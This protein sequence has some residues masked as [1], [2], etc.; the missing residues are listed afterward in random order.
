VA[1]EHLLATADAAIAKGEMIVA[2]LEHA[3]AAL[4]ASL[5]QPKRV[6]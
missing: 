4:S 3:A 1:K 5:P 2:H 6:Q